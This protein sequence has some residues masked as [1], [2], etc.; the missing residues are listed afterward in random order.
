MA[1]RARLTR[2][3]GNIIGLSSQT[4]DTAGSPGNPSYSLTG[5]CQSDMMKSTHTHSAG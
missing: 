1:G 3:G 5:P 4:P 2:S